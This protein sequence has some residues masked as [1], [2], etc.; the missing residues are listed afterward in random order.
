ML[1][2]I[3][4]ALLCMILRALMSVIFQALHCVLT[5]TMLCVIRQAL[6]CMLLHPLLSVILEAMFV[7]DIARIV[8]VLHIIYIYIYICMHCVWCRRHRC[9]VIIAGID[10]SDVTGIV[11]CV[12][13]NIIVCDV[14]ATVVCDIPGI[15]VRDIPDIPAYM[16]N[17]WHWCVWYWRHCFLMLQVF[18][19]FR[20]L[21]IF[22][23]MNCKHYCL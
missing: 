2:S 20:V 9:V 23:V 12:I 16:C 1:G 19:F 5:Q 6:V 15:I 18:Y 14:A 22:C 13:I 8:F 10:V 3:L 21:R 4:Y 17:W 11:I 7:C